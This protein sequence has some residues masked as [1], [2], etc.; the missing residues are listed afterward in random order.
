M[1]PEQYDAARDRVG[2]EERMPEGVVLHAAWFEDG[3]LHVTDVWETQEDW[4]RFL[5][6]RLAPTLQDLGVTDQP[7]FHVVPLH[8]R[9]IGPGVSGA[10]S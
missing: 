2:W 9:F 4:D 1:T 7:D 8:R 5:A 3:V 10:A 6:E